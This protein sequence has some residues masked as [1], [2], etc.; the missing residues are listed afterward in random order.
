MMRELVYGTDRLVIRDDV[1]MDTLKTE[2]TA[3]LAGKESAEEAA[4]LIQSKLS[5]YMSEHYG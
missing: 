3:F 1:V 5:L 2:I 4:R